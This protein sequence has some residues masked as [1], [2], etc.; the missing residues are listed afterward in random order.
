MLN[1]FEY[2]RKKVVI[3]HNFKVIYEVFLIK[4]L[5]REENFAASEIG[6]C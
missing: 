1:L 3:L 6:F 2:I 5:S 4:I